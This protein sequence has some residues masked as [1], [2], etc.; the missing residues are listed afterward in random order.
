MSNVRVITEVITIG[1]LLKSTLEEEFS[2]L[3]DKNLEHLEQVQIEKVELLQS[4]EATW[5]KEDYES[6][7]VDEPLWEE[8][9]TLISEC[10]EAHIRNDLLLKRQLEVVRTV[11]AS[12][13]QRSADNASNL[14]DKMGKMKRKRQPLS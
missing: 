7:A 1:N 6:L 12:L 11:L 4:L 2:A 3:S 9:R 10:K 14:Y 5:P 8:A 13:T